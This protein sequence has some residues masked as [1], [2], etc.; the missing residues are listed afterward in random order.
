MRQEAVWDEIEGE[1]WTQRSDTA[2]GPIEG[3]APQDVKGINTMEELWVMS[4]I[5]SVKDLKSGLI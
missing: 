2:C 1:K 4:V 3:K 5:H